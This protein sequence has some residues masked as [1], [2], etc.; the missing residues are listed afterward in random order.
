MQEKSEKSDGRVDCDHV[1]G[2][3]DAAPC[4]LA[5]MGSAIQ[6]QAMKRLRKPRHRTGSL[7][8]RFDRS[9]SH[10]ALAPRHRRTVRRS[11]ADAGKPPRASSWPMPSGPS[12]CS[13]TAG[14]PPPRCRSELLHDGTSVMLRRLPFPLPGG[15]LPRASSAPMPPEPSCWRA[16]RP[17]PYVACV[18]KELVATLSLACCSAAWRH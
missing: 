5:Q 15:T 1:S 12:R 9:S 16:P 18:A 7:D 17:R 8:R 2:L 11:P 14:R 10:S 3:S 6:S 13:I 4:P